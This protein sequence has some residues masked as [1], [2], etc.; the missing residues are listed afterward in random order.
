[1]GERERACIQV[2]MLSSSRVSGGI[3][4]DANVQRASSENGTRNVE[5][6]FFDAIS[7][8]GFE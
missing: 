3:F 6:L 4:L 8:R 5:L 1:M 7:L 2:S